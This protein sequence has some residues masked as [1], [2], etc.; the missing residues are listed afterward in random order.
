MS[1][2]EGYES[3][4]QALK[5]LVCLLDSQKLG[6]CNGLVRTHHIYSGPGFTDKNPFVI[7]FSSANCRVLDISVA[8]TKDSNGSVITKK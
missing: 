2:A 8:L 1:L 4:M 5:T 7:N 3:V 6:S